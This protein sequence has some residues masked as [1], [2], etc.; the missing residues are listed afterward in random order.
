MCCDSTIIE[1]YMDSQIVSFTEGRIEPAEGVE[2]M[3]RKA[4]KP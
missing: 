2:F 1:E 4:E 3:Q